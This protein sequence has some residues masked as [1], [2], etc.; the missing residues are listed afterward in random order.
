MSHGSA[1]LRPR[2]STDGSGIL[3]TMM[4]TLTTTGMPAGARAVS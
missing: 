2:P 4:T 3:A 1:F